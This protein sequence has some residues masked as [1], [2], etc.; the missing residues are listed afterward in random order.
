[1]DTDTEPSKRAHWAKIALTAAA[2]FL[3]AMSGL[4]VSVVGDDTGGDDEVAETTTTTVATTVPE[5]TTTTTTIDVELA[6]EYAGQ[7]QAAAL[8]DFYERVIA[9]TTTTTLPPPP[10]PTTVYVP[11][12]PPVQTSSG[13][14][15]WPWDQLVM[16]EASGNWHINTGNGFYGGLQ[17]VQS[18]WVGFGGQQYASYAHLAAPWQQVEIAKK[19]QAVQGW[20]AWPGCAR[21]LGL[22][23]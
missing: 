19:V 1:M 10:P 5:P 15:G 8:E 7:L 13:S 9:S 20:G 18:T 14:F 6:A 12:P 23:F 4:T 17:F 11:P 2:V 22:P 16:C 21:Q 3:I